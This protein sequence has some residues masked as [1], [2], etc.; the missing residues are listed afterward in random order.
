MWIAERES[1]KA[2]T[3]EDRAMAYVQYGQRQDRDDAR[4]SLLHGILDE[5]K[6]YTDTSVT[7]FNSYCVI[8]LSNILGRLLEDPELDSAEHDGLR[9]TI[10]KRM[11]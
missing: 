9:F 1:T 11:F 2:Q 5:I 3:D 4:S 8:R 7:Q 10:R 6:Y